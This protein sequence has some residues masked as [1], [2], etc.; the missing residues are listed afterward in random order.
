MAAEAAAATPLKTPKTIGQFA[1]LHVP[2]RCLPRAAFPA[3]DV[4]AI[5][6]HAQQL[7]ESQCKN[8]DPS[9]A[10]P[11]WHPARAKAASSGSA[12]F[13]GCEPGEGR[14]P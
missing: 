9:G 8:R 7:G 6:C 10:K 4:V 3:F 5:T 11:R 13:R 12:V 2:I 1:Y 14:P